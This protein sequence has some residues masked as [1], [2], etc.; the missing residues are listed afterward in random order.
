MKLSEVLGTT[1]WLLFT[2]DVLSVWNTADFYRPSINYY[3]ISYVRARI[4]EWGCFEQSLHIMKNRITQP[5]GP[6][7][8][9]KKIKHNDSVARLALMPEAVEDGF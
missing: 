2:Q 1:F 6:H 5:V 9:G 7:D 8:G 3:G 4:L